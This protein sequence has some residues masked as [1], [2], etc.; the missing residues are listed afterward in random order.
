MRRILFA[1]TFAMLMAAMWLSLTAGRIEGPLAHPESPVRNILY[2]HVPSSICALL[3]F[4]IILVTSIS[5]LKTGNLKWDL[6]SA[7]AAEVG[8]IFATVLNVTGMIFSRAEWSTWWTPSLRLFSSAVLWFLYVV[9]LI[10]RSNLPG[11]RVRKARVCAVFGII[12]FL[13]VPMVYASARFLPDIHR[14]SFSLDL[15][16][17]R[18]TFFLNMI[19]TVLLMVCLIWLKTDI[20]KSEI[21]LEKQS[22]D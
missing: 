20:L 8:L 5:Y 18:F 10:L 21:E 9:Y 22:F 16:V 7:S 3:S 17:Q 14:P 6:V 4:T 19:S 1:F 13:V 12:G 15:G 11:S 2:V